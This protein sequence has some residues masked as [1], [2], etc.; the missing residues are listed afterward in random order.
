MLS[1]YIGDR[2][3]L[4]RALSQN[5]GLTAGELAASTNTHECYIREWLEQQTVA[6]ILE[7]DDEN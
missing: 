3:C 6:G 7:V 2:L 4:Y 1:I 5:D